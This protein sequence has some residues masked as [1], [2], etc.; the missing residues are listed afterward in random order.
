M[1]LVFLLL[2]GIP[3][4]TMELAVGRASRRS[5]V[6]RYKALE[7]IRSR[8]HIHDW[9]CMAGCYLLLGL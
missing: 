9:F 8:W 4:L 5:A 6:Q 1:Y 7:P 3:V 2:M